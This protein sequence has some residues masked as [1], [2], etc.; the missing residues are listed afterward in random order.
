LAG[1]T[2]GFTAGSGRSLRRGKIDTSLLIIGSGETR[3]LL[4]LL[5]SGWF[6]FG[7]A[8]GFGFFCHSFIFLPRLTGL[9]DRSFP[10]GKSIMVLEA[11]IVNGFVPN[12]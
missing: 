4:F 11:M 12:L 10:A 5:F 1:K 7:C 8:F 6:L 3:T 9:R 2:R